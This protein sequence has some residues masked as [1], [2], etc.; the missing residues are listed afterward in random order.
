[1]V[2]Q[3]YATMSTKSKAQKQ[4]LVNSAATRVL[5]ADERQELIRNA[6]RVATSDAASCL[7]GLDHIA[8]MTRFI[9][10]RVGDPTIAIHNPMTQKVLQQILGDEL[11]LTRQ[12]KS[13]IVALLALVPKIVNLDAVVV[14]VAVAVLDVPGD[15]V[16]MV[17]DHDDISDS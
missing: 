3:H 5:S 4:P 14:D 12:K 15:V 6:L 7:Y 17:V 11:T 1:M 9:N 13:A 16:A 8:V 10:H 2:K